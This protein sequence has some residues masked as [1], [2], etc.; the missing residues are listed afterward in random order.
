V[1]LRP[2]GLL[3]LLKAR[4]ALI[5]AIAFACASYS[6]E[7]TTPARVGPGTAKMAARLEQITRSNHPMDNP[8]RSEER[9][10]FLREHAAEVTNEVEQLQ[11]RIVLGRELLNA[12]EPEEALVEFNRAVMLRN[13][14]RN[15]SSRVRGDLE[16]LIAMAHLR[17][18]E[19][20]NCVAFHGP[21]SCLVPLSPAAVHKDQQGSRAAIAQLTNILSR[22]S[23]VLNAPWLLNIAYMTVGEYPEKVP[24]Q[25]LLPRSV[26]A[27][28]CPFPRFRNIADDV[29]LALEG[30]AGGTVTDDFDNDG[31]LD[32]MVSEWGLRDQLRFYISHGDGTFTERTDQAGLTGLVGGLNMVQAD[33]NNDGFVDVLVLRGAWMGASGR[34]PNSLLRNN[35]DGTFEDVTEQ[36]GMLSFYPTQT[37]TWWDFNNDGHLDLFIGNESSGP[38]VHPCELYRNNGNGTFT[39]C[40]AAAGVAV[41]GFVKGV[42]SGD[43]DNDGWTDLY[44]SVRGQTNILFH[45]EGPAIGSSR[46]NAWQFRNVTQTAGVGEPMFSFPTWFFDYDNDGWQDIFVSGYGLAGS[47]DFTADYLGLP[48]TSERAR[49]YH[50]N[51][52]GTFS[53]VSK[54]AGLYRLLHAMGSNFGDLDNDGYLD[55][56]LGTGDPDLETIIPNRMFRNAEGKRFQDITTAGGFG[57]LQKGHGIS[58]ADLDNDG[59]QDIYESLG[60]AYSGDGFRN[61]LFENPGTTNRWIGLKL[62]GV[63]SNRSAIGA[64][65]KLTVQGPNGA[66]AIC[67]TVNSGG[68]FGCNPLAQHIGIGGATNA[69]VEILWPTSRKTQRFNNLAAGQWY[70]IRE[71]SPEAAP[72]KLKRFKL[73][74]GTVTMVRP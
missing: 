28:E 63:Q 61:A 47:G 19:L 54:Q 73:G 4:L 36:T 33:Y 18:G 21:E 27:S 26:F 31:D 5:S 25:W 45:N 70:H 16:F 15:V 53:D 13:R 52:N 22:R 64:R 58:F 9:A 20:D 41:V 7:K 35:G 1:S 51:G 6:A 48:Y 8:F 43:Y 67:K 71:D 24:P 49:L 57:H 29:G 2:F 39:E 42:N 55:F 69:A 60:G 66:R 37:A 38:N 72:L 65:I 34:Y 59:D 14:L 56:Y 17:R 46:S 62:Q 40:A 10:A 11:L 50:N 44:L 30:L 68:S 12:G 32:L 74:G 23:E 3:T